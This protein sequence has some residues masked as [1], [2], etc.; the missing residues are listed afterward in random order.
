MQSGKSQAWLTRFLFLNAILTFFL[1]SL[2]GK[3][4]SM[5]VGMSV[6]D[7]PQSYGYNMFFFP[8]DKWLGPGA[9]GVFFEHSHRLLASLV[10]LFSIIAALWVAFAETRFWMKVMAFLA[11]FSVAFQGLLGGLRVVLDK[12]NL[13]MEFGLTHATFAQLFFSLVC[14]L[15]LFRSNWWRNASPHP[16]AASLR[17]WILATCCIIFVQLTVAATMRHQHAG[18]AVTDFPLAYGK[19][20]PS[21]SPAAIASYNSSRIEISDSNPITASAVVLHMIHRLL[22]L[23]IVGL[24]ATCALK[25]RSI[26]GS[27]H[28]ITVYNFLWLGLVALQFCLGIATVLTG[29]S[30]DIATAH[31]AVGSLTLMTGALLSMG[32]YRITSPRTALNLRPA[33]RM[34]SASSQLA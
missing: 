26:L 8:F 13:G 21:I 27:S 28:K 16:R 14:A 31:V 30:A 5:G 29:K 32:C 11:L 1:V 9:G 6:P 25:S 23:V 17:P 33:P 22:A 15:V 19:I 34:Q 7:W 20:I 4:T 18:L 2:G 10:G 12:Y 3:V 24:I